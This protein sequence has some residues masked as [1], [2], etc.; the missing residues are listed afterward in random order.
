MSVSSQITR[1]QQD[2]NTVRNKMVNLGLAA[3]SADLDDLATAVDGIVNRGAVAAE[4][5]IGASYTIP[6][7]YHNG[8][9]T[10]LG[11]QGSEDFKLQAK[12]ATPTKQSQSITPDSGF[13]GL[14]SVA[15]AP[16]PEAY[17]DVS[18]VD[19][20]A[21][22]V[23]ANKKIVS[24]TGAIVAGT[25]PNNGKVTAI[26]DTETTSYSIP[27]GYHNGQGA[28]SIDLEEKTATPSESTQLIT[29]TEGKVL[30]QVEVEPI[31][32]NY[33]SVDNADA[34][35]A[36]I[37]S[38]KKAVI[39]DA[40]GNATLATGSMPN[41]G[42][43]SVV[44][45]AETPSH[46]FGAGYYS[47]GTASVVLE[48]KTATP[49]ES[50]QVIEP[51]EGKVIGSVT[52][53]RIPVKYGDTTN[54]DASAANVL[55]G[56]KALT[57]VDG[58]A[59]EITGTMPNQGAFNRTLDVSTPSVSV[60]M[61]Y[62]NGE[63]AV[64]IQVETKSATPTES[65]QTITPTAGK[66]L[67]QVN[68]KYGDASGMTAIASHLLEGDTAITWDSVNNKAIEI[69]GTLEAV[70]PVS[71]ELAAGESYTIPAG[72]HDGEGVVSAKSLASQTGVDLG[73]TAI[74]ATHVVSGYQGWVNGEKVSGTM[75]N[76]GAISGSIDG[77]TTT[78]F[79]VPAGYTS[80]G[81]VSLTNDIEE[82]LAAI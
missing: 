33:G 36:N 10:V 4:V 63:G 25:M 20:V 16:I 81:S 64:S 19:A 65:A 26:L 2:R 17:Q 28:V 48:D 75:A 12:S 52:I 53:N 71:E 34:T 23:L 68:V 7:G 21:G 15:V 51:S 40:D 82:A 18:A 29:P 54:A 27:A 6:A 49:T 70:E 69:E 38:G 31:P 9:G 58:S 73:K 50:Q 42:A 39:Q 8:S 22:D 41:Q 57:N 79:S 62:H 47:G 74:D 5:Q 30:S 3:S 59:V 46:S 37:L 66:V 77:L 76:N 35:A 14:S 72:I 55:V 11:V 60:P 24:K 13:Y 1:I 67:G 78:S 80:G 32:D 44:L 43:I 45:D 61:G 56:K